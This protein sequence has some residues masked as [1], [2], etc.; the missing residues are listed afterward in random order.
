MPKSRY[1]QSPCGQERDE[2][3]RGTRKRCTQNIFFCDT[4]CDHTSILLWRGC[5]ATFALPST[6]PLPFLA[7]LRLQV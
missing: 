3:E 1:S 4:R 7:L 5:T 6:S 2:R